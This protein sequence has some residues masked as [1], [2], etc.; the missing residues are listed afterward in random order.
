VGGW[1]DEDGAAVKS[2]VLWWL[3]GVALMQCRVRKQHQA[4]VLVAGMLCDKVSYVTWASCQ[5]VVTATALGYHAVLWF[6]N[7]KFFTA[8]TQ[9]PRLP[10]AAVTQNSS[11]LCIASAA[12][13]CALS[14]VWQTLPV[15]AVCEERQS[16]LLPS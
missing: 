16:A 1:I 11:C 9:L 15:C 3:V 7:S 8:V 14:A 5:S 4:A 10:G 2:S 6:W 13:C 12:R